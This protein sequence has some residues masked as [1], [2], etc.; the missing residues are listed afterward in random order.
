MSQSCEQQ[1]V[2]LKAKGL[3]K[4]FGGQVV[5]DHLG[6]ELRQRDIVVLRGDNGSGKTTLLNILTGNVEPDSGEIQLFARG[7]M[8]ALSFPRL[9]W[10]VLNPADHFTPER[11]ARGGVGRTWQDTRLFLSQRV[12][13]NI[14][15]A[16]RRQLGE[17]PAAVLFCQS[18]VRRAEQANGTAVDKIL[19]QLELRNVSNS[20]A[21]EISQGQ[22]KRVA[23][24]RALRGGAQVLFLD[25]PL[26]GLD[27]SGIKNGLAL[28][29]SVVRDTH[30]TLVIVEHLFNIPKIL[31]LATKVWTLQNG[32][33]RVELPDQV[34]DKVA[35]ELCTHPVHV[36]RR[37]TD[38]EAESS[39]QSLGRNASLTTVRL[40]RSNKTQPVLEVTDLI[41]CR[42]KRSVIGTDADGTAH[43][44][45]FVL[46]DGE[47][48]LLEAPNGWGKTTLLEAIMGLIPINS[49]SIKFNGKSVERVE[50]WQR[51]RLGMIFLQSQRHSFPSLT[52]RETIR[53]AMVDSV[54]NELT[55]L[56]DCHISELSGGERQKVAITCVR[57]RHHVGFYDEPFAALDSAGIRSLWEDLLKSGA[58]SPSLIAL[59]SIPNDSLQQ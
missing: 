11:L 27:A 4:A 40:K 45:S 48:A 15:I 16:L 26:A 44:L 50:P 17:N 33:L 43:G 21:D 51:A 41:V 8:E 20:P 14:A 30:V 2:I 58:D 12:F 37:L 29:E 3:C 36:F 13:E 10:S 56:L 19:E 47:L 57:R 7:A 54:P 6:L 32:K 55:S 46:H 59:P 5:L 42:G 24:G 38:T 28:L 35:S 31:S 52:V 49:G 39:S 25:E 18:R 9:W 1:N 53:L 22:S 34:R 23:I